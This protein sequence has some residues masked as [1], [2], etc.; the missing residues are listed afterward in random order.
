M[1]RAR[2]RS[3]PA[4]A[5]ARATAPAAPAASSAKWTEPRACGWALSGTT[6]A[7]GGTTA[8]TRA[9]ATSRVCRAAGPRRRASCGR[10]SYSRHAPSPRRSGSATRQTTTRTRARAACRPS[11][12]RTW[13][14]SWWVPRACGQSRRGSSSSS[15]SSSRAHRCAQRG[16]R[17]RWRRWHPGSR[18]WT[19]REA[20]LAAGQTPRR[21]RPSCPSSRRCT[22]T[23]PGWGRW[24]RRHWGPSEGSPCSAS[25]TA[26]WAGR[27]RC[28]S[29]RRRPRWRSCT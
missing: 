18:R 16:H 15:A 20:S 11:R 12:A 19:C 6:P 9:R 21:W 5:C 26:R 25:T 28:A 8:R 17:G 24:T 27:T 2:T 29:Q 22:S 14:W 10:E 13:A 4:R 23:V 3:P 7:A 1:L